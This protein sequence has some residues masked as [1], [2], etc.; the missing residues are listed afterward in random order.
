M[1]L[2]ILV[3]LCLVSY[4]C[5]AK[6]STLARVV[7]VLRPTLSVLVSMGWVIM[8]LLPF[9]QPEQSLLQL[10]VGYL[11][12]AHDALCTSI[13]QSSLY[14]PH[15]Q[16]VLAVIHWLWVIF[17]DVLAWILLTASC[18]LIFV[19]YHY[20]LDEWLDL[21]V[22]TSFDWARDNI[23][24]VQV[25]LEKQTES[26]AKSA[27]QVLDKD[28]LRQFTL[29]L[30]E[31]GRSAT[32]II[33]ELT[34]AATKEDQKWIDGKTSGIVYNDY[35]KHL[36]LM[37]QVYKAYSVSNPLHPGFWPKLNQCE[38]E[39]IAMTAALTHAPQPFGAMSSGG[40]ESI[41]LA[42]RAHLS[43]YGQR[44]RIQYPELICSS[45]A[46]AAVD[47][48]CEM[49]HIRKVVI[50]CDDG[51]TF[52]L[53]SQA[54]RRRITSNTIMIYASAPSYPHGVIDPIATLSELALEFDIGLHVDACLGG[55][56]LAFCERAPIV[57]FRHEGVT[58]MSL[59]T[60]KYGYAS[61]GTSIVLY[62]HKKLRHGQYFCYPH[63][64]GG[65]YATPTVAGS[66]PGA[67]TACAWASLVSLGRTGFVSRA[68]RI[69]EAARVIAK[70]IRDTPGLKLMTPDPYMVVCFGSDEVDIYRV[71]DAMKTSGW[72][73]NSLQNPACIHVC[74][75]LP[76]TSK[77]A[78]FVS[79]LQ[80]A[81]SYVRKEGKAGN[82][83]GTAG[84]YGAGTNYRN[85][86]DCRM[87]WIILHLS[88][89]RLL[90]P[91]LCRYCFIL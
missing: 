23:A 43:Y 74:V 3:F 17:E 54:V 16:F 87:R 76:M 84:I 36:E 78:L 30:P 62:R 8:R 1:E 37:Q 70:G 42:I 89:T 90:L 81:V 12:Q 9:A 56:V 31:H 72:T 32:E 83:K 80:A 86:C 33:E 59:D 85:G 24:F 50:D 48:A 5:L 41:I 22:K 77:V 29:V 88:H 2:P 44:R 38:A 11:A 58:S 63:W 20:S 18:R 39:V 49:F 66:R 34:T 69:V 6:W 25:E 14:H 55:F 57:D 60:H 45:S 75:T 51:S 21:I 68:S 46:H 7:R 10:G 4:F 82:S 71:L 13:Q 15:C 67:L 47:K 91:F 28:P 52:Q 53:R 19:F 73:L 65:M 27:D 26:F 61:K 79:D 35:K 64:T 40:T